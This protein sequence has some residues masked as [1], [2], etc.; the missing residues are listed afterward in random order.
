MD[1]RQLSLAQLRQLIGEPVTHLGKPCHVIEV[2]ADGPSLVLQANGC[3]TEIQ[4]NQFG[5]P[6]REVPSI[7][8]VPLLENGAVNPDFL[9]LG[10]VDCEHDDDF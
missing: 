7:Y 5:E 4:D 3:A 10:L 1:C 2:L 8:L 9:H 6:A